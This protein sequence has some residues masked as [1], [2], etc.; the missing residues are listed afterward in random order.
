[1]NSKL[2]S[3]LMDISLKN[4][5]EFNIV[6][7]NY[8]F[9]RF[10]IR[11]SKSKYK[12]KIIIKGGYLISLVYGLEKRTTIDIDTLLKNLEV[13]EENII[14]LVE[15]II[16]IDIDDN[17]KFKIMK[18]EEIKEFDSYLGFRV[19]L[20]YLFENLKDIIK[21]DFATGDIVTPKEIEHVY[22][23]MLYNDDISI[24]TYNKETILAEK[25]ETVLRRLGS[26]S[27]MK[28]F[29]DIHLIY[30]NDFKNLDKKVLSDALI[31]TFNNRD[32][33]DSVE[34]GL[35]ILERNT[36]LINRWK[37]YQVRNDFAKNISYNDIVKCIENI[38]YCIK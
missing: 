24:L 27:R 31:H 16:R 3:E 5:V 21:L 15:D 13:N 17:I 35:K 37:S 14:L 10:V 23:P 32:Y 28:D 11:I 4:K 8:I 29:Y 6:L 25:I 38:L 26:N 18:I 12:D 7:K 22:K 9:D 1:M 20:E 33:T 36:M 34:L 2:K 30:S 19:S